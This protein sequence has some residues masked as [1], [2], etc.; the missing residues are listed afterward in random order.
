MTLCHQQGDG[1]RSLS[2]LC[3]PSCKCAG[4]Q[5]VIIKITHSQEHGQHSEWNT[6]PPSHPALTGLPL[7]LRNPLQEENVINCR[8]FLIIWSVVFSVG[9]E[10]NVPEAWLLFIYWSFNHLFTWLLC[11]HTESSNG[12]RAGCEPNSEPL[13]VFHLSSAQLYTPS[14]QCAPASSTGSRLHMQLNLYVLTVLIIDC[15]W[16][17]IKRLVYRELFTSLWSHDKRN[18]F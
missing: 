14:T 12:Q 15:L 6:T 5:A 1:R 10:W 7:R 8:C 11:M 3:P 2:Y 17:W 13:E 18:F 4:K 16:R 9:Y